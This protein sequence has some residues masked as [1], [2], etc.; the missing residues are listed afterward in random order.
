VAGTA[1]NG[2]WRAGDT[3]AARLGVAGIAAIAVIGWIRLAQGTPASARHVRAR[4]GVQRR[5][6]SGQANHGPFGIKILIFRTD[7]G[8]S[9]AAAV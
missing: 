3:A 6:V 4:P 7:G 8:C 2:A 5:R 1:V 9:A